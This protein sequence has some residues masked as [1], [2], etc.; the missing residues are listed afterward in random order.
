MPRPV[1]RAAVLLMALPLFKA[2]AAQTIALG[3]EDATVWAQEQ[4]AAGTITGTN[5]GTLY[6]N[7]EPIPFTAEGGVFAVPLRLTEPETEVVAC[8]ASG[9]GEV[10]HDTLR[11]ALG[12]VPRPEA[13]VRASVAARTVTFEGRVLANPGGPAL[14]FAWAED[15]GNPAALGLV[16]QNDSTAVAVVPEGAPPGEYYVDW[17]VSAAD[18]D[19]RRAR[20]FVTVEAGGGIRPFVLETD[21]AAWVDRATVYEIA[22]RYFANQ[23][24]GRFE[25]I[26]QKL[27]EIAAL[28][29][30]A[31]WLQPIYPNA[32]G[33]QAYDVTDYFGIWDD[34]GTEADLHELIETAHGLGLKVLLDLVP[35]HTSIAHPYAE[36]AIAHGE[37]SHYFDFY[38]R[39]FDDAP[40]ANNYHH[41][42][43]GAMTFVYYFWD[44]LV[45]LNYHNPEV[46]RHLI[47]AARYWV[48]TFD[49]DGY[50]F[51]AV[52]GVQARTPDFLPELRAALKRIKPEAFLLAEAKATDEDL[53]ENRFDAAYDW[54]ADMGYI[55]EWAWQRSSPETT[56]FN[57]GLEQFRARDLHFALTDHGRG[58]HPDAVVFRY[59]ENN[60]TPRFLANHSARQTKMAATLLFSLPGIPMLYYGQE[61]GVSNPF[62][63]FPSAFPIAQYDHDGFLAHYKHLL[64]LRRAFPALYGDQFES[65]PVEPANVGARTYA[66]RRWEGAEHVVGAINMSGDDLTAE[67]A[68]PVDAMGLDPETTY[69]LTDLF[70]GDALSGTGAELAGFPVDVPAYTTRLFA[71]AD[72]VVAVPVATEPVGAPPPSGFALAPNHPN[73][74][75]GRTTL[76]YTVAEGGPVRL[77]VYDLLGRE[78]ARLVD[79]VVPA[80]RHA[81]VFDGAG[82][83]SGVYVARLEGG[84]RVATRRMVLVR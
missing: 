68:L 78:V 24:L 82:L 27:P 30:T 8:V 38:Q 77:V 5:A 1:I 33:G 15:P 65:V 67:L 54:T 64:R 34:L 60:D 52:W 76:P 12:Y 17:T 84:G 2:A 80:G 6:V 72:S 71:V 83:A 50:R 37:R 63:S 39:E 7:G 36:D 16:V 20:T 70:T 32:N 74:F 41:L 51:D 55:S 10:C 21:H 18:G 73:P 44:D 48:E 81:A 35:N 29:V 26:T 45:N 79:G 3:E 75:A 19:G 53:F 57:S 9:G 4:V 56:L 59:L 40:Y 66:Y 62:P 49:V 28:G 42:H 25:H 13:E 47:E 58:Y 14:S 43:V 46:R 11:W 69:Y 22:P 61:V 23:Y 31:V